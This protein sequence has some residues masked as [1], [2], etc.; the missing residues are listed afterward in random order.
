MPTLFYIF[1][2]RFYFW[3]NEHE[4]IHVHVEKGDAEAKFNINPVELVYNHG[5]RPNELKLIESLVEENAE[6][7]LEHWKV[8]NPKNE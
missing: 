2:F 8:R 3:S 6:V 4:P 1:G 5:F 7:I